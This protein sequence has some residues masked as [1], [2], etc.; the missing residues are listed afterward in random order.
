VRSRQNFDGGLALRIG[1]GVLRE[2]VGPSIALTGPE[3]VPPSAEAMKAS[4][5]TSVL[6][7]DVK[8]AS[9]VGFEILGGSDG[10][11]SR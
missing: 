6:C 5:L 9:V 1:A 4:W 10:T 7:Q 8:G 3:T 11:S 2:R